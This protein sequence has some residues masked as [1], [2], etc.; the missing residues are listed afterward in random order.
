MPPWRCPQV[1]PRVPT[2]PLPTV[3]VRKTRRSGVH[4]PG[5]RKTRWRC[6]Q[7]R[8]RKTR[9]EQKAYVNALPSKQKAHRA[10]LP[11]RQKAHVAAL[12][13][14]RPR[15]EHPTGPQPTAAAP[16]HWEHQ[17]AWVEALRRLS[18]GG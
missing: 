6:P 13:S 3:G 9:R 10:A 15:G 5:V 11:S 2:R 8:V 18:G 12:P 16:G 4:K 17:Q 14:R 1:L 7:V